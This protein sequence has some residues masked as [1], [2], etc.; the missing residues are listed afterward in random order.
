MI[1][2]RLL[3]FVFSVFCALR[4]DAAPTALPLAVDF[5][6][7]DGGFTPSSETSWK[8]GPPT[9]GPGAARSGTQVW[10]TNLTSATYSSNEDAILTSGPIDLSAAAGQAILIRWSQYLITEDGFDEGFVEVSK[11]SGGT[12]EA[13]VGPRSGVV[14]STWTQQ[15]VML[16]PS[17]A[18]ESFLIRFRLVSDIVPSEG[19]FFMDDLHITAAPVTP[20]VMLQNFEAGDGGYVASGTNS[21][22]AFGTPVSAPGS[23]FSG[24]SAWATN[25]NGLYNAS[26]ES[27]LA[28]PVFD[29]GAFA[30]KLLIVSWRQF[31]DV[32][33]G[34]DFARV[35]VSK[36]SGATWQAAQMEESGAINV[37][38]WTRR[39]V[40]VDSSYATAG[41]RIRFRLEAD[42]T[43]QFDGWAID[44]VAVFATADLFPIASS[45]ARS[46]PQD[47]SIKF[48][49]AQFAAAYQDPDGGEL[50]SIEIS[51]VPA[52]GVLKLA[53][54]PVALNQTI[55]IT[56][57]NDF[58]YEPAT[59]TSGTDAFVWRAANQFGWSAPAT[60]TLNV[61]APTPDVVIATPPSNIAVNPGAP[62]TF[63]VIALSTISLSYQWRK[64]QQPI[65][66]AN[67]ATFTIGLA[68]EGDEGS[69]DVVV[70]NAGDQEISA[71][72]NLNV[73]DPVAFN[74]PPAPVT[75]NEGDDAEF[76]VAA[77]GSGRLD[78]QWLKNNQ[79]I[80]EATFATLSLEEVTPA[81]EASYS[82]VVTNI[83]GSKTSVPAA[84]TV[85]RAPRIGTQP[86]SVGRLVN[87]GVTFSVE[88]DGAGSLTYQ[89]LKDGV[90]IPGATAPVLSMLKLLGLNSGDY[91]VRVSND[92]ATTES[93][94]AKLSV[95]QWA[96]V[97]GTYQDVLVLEN[98]GALN[99]TPFSGRLTV[100]LA[101]GGRVTGLLEYRGFRHV[102]TGKFGEELLVES[103][104]KR[105]AD[106][107]LS[108]RLEL[109]P[110][111]R[112]IHATVTHQDGGVNFES[113]A[114]LPRNAYHRLRNA[115]LLPGR[116]NVVLAPL[117][118]AV[119]G[120]SAPGC[121]VS[122]VARSG[123]IMI[124][125]DLP[126][127]RVLAAGAILDP[128]GRVPLYAT[129][130]PSV[131]EVAGRLE[132]ETAGNTR[133]VAGSASW[134]ETRAA[135]TFVPAPFNVMLDAKGSLYTRPV[136]GDS[137]LT[138]PP[139][140]DSLE[141]HINGPIAVTAITRW[142]RVLG[143]NSFFVDPE[144]IEK[145]RFRADLKTGWVIGSYFDATTNGR[146]SIKAVTLQAQGE[147]RGFVEGADN[148]G[149]VLLVPYIP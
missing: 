24:A 71:A 68:A 84:L 90:P 141:F 126:N 72:A 88:A 137:V 52:N 35:E 66:G 91:S 94:V 92:F 139:G 41:F 148:A 104:I 37:A 10:G 118:G 109:D 8:W 85:R 38:G 18:T 69:Y 96:E 113:T 138:L 145:I 149:E 7:N 4:T 73:N 6:L 143:P 89:W 39:Q 48:S 61:L 75:V 86:I 106:S 100:A 116:Y 28:S 112:S 93:D 36:D 63:E 21:S 17:Y 74:T 19:G 14:H 58:T 56:A 124:R 34:Y 65:L 44:D 128:F 134:R 142:V 146:R 15:M 42:D 26:E 133:T 47:I 136:A 95:F 32:E 121:I 81:D 79:P 115:T 16:D 99:T 40:L 130:R 131:G 107:P 23:A 144:T 27:A 97:A 125:I 102:F 82:C 2:F 117:P 49:A 67:G 70:T 57:L 46:T 33:E 20:A 45:F 105:G 147:V 98:A 83:V 132:I 54:A 30:G 108:A 77:T 129:F 11:D 87:R 50:A 122:T 13:V 12:W 101:V 80:P 140:S 22:W 127:G 31:L 59:G 55:A 9:A 76:T 110:E 120:P 29:L 103:V 119:A 111:T 3:A 25:L 5:E 53:G 62:A 135:G 51:Q 64:N 78:Y 43:F 60:V 123:R 114:M 1:H